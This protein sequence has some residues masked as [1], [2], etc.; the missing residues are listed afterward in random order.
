M[1]RSGEARLSNGTQIVFLS[2][3][4]IREKGEVGA[5][6]MPYSERQACGHGDIGGSDL[7]AVFIY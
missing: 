5:E 1:T 7:S 2:W 4:S 3:I 6:G